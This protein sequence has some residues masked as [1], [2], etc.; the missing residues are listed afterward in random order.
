MSQNLSRFFIG[1][2]LAP[3]VILLH[4]CGHYAAAAAFGCTSYF[5]FAETSVRL[6][7]PVSP[8]IF[9]LV[10]AAGPAVDAFLTIGGFLWL[11]RLRHGR[12]QSA[13]TSTDWL[14]TFPVLFAARWLRC[15]ASPPSHPVPK[16]ETTLS[17]SFGFP[18]WFLPYLLALA[19]LAIL[20]A[21]IRLH[22]RGSRL[23]PFVSAFLGLCLGGVLWL[24]VFG[25]RV[26]P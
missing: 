12:L 5:H 13:V 1:V 18:Q 16:D 21:T 26:L 23:V 2:V 20:T 3:L 11:R 24:K 9:R 4:E 14:A 6:E 22:P 10:T 19:A 8:H 15:L 7:Q 25:P 17:V